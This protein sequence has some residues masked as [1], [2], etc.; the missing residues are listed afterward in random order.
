MPL[1]E[2][3]FTVEEARREL[4]GLRRQLARIMELLEALR[5]AHLDG[6][7]VEKLVRSNG[8]ASAQADYAPEIAELQKL[9]EE[10]TSRGIEI[11][12]LNRGLVDFPHWRDGEE[13]YLCWLYGEEDILY[14]HTV[15]A[16][17]GGRT[18]IE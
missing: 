11:K 17:F 14:Y 2:K 1:F 13:V 10:I 9:S 15:S 6:E 8:R 3:H 4:P 16:G 12:D 5:A 7:R 18:P